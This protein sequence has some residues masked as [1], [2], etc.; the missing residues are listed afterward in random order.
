M[1][2]PS[3]QGMNTQGTATAKKY[4]E[5]AEATKENKQKSQSLPRF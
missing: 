5:N 2:L 4:D 3:I 1:T